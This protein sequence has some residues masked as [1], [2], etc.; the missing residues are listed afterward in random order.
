MLSHHFVHE[1]IHCAPS[2]NVYS[3]DPKSIAGV[4]MNETCFVCIGSSEKD[5]S[6]KDPLELPMSPA[7]VNVPML[8]YKYSH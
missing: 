5:C 4:K 2:I 6:L 1:N 3:P 8:P 7:G